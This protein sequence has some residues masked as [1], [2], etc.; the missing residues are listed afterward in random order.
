VATTG[1]GGGGGVAVVIDV[2]IADSGEA[3]TSLF[4]I[5]VNV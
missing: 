2:E 5:S 4:A 3:P 1:T